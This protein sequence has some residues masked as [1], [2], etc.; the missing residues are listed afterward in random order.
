MTNMRLSINVQVVVRAHNFLS[1][2]DGV[3]FIDLSDF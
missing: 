1:M 3:K 2:H